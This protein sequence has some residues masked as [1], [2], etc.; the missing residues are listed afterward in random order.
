MKLNTFFKLFIIFILIGTCSKPQE[1]KFKV[2][3][4]AKV[5]SDSTFMTIEKTLNKVEDIRKVGNNAP[6]TIYLPEGTYRLNSTLKISPKYGALKLEGAGIDKTII[7]GSKVLPLQWKKYNDAIW[8]AQVPKDKTFDQIYINGVPQILARYPNYNENGGHWQGHAADA[9]SPERV[10]SWKNPKGG[11]VNV[12]HSGEWGGFHYLV[13]GVDDSGALILSKGHQNNR[14]SKMHD[15]YRMVE[16]IFEELDSPKEWYLS[17]NNQLFYWPEADIDLE[18]ATVEVVQLKHLIDI[19]GTE[20]NPVKN[21]SI[22][23][24]KFEH[25]QR[26]LFED[27]E[28]LLRSDWTIYRGG[29]LFI[30]GTESIKIKDCELTNLG[31][32][33]IFVSS[34]N[35]DVSITNNHIYNCG[36]TAINFV[37]S[38]TA[39]RSPA[40]QYYKFVKLADMDTIKGPKNNKYPSASK[41]DNNLIYRIGRIEKQTAGVNISMAMD[42]TVS[43]NTIYDVPRAG[44]NICDGTWG[45]HIIEQNDVFNTVL[46]T[47]DHGAFNSWGRDRFWHPNRSVLD[48]IVANHPDI[49]KWDAIHT[50]IIRNNRF[51]CD[52]GW[53]IDLDDGSSNY[54]IYNNVCLNGGIKF[55]EGFYRTA[56]NNILINNGFH[57]HVWFKNSED[58]FRKN[59]VLT[60]HK[61]IRLQAWGKEVDFNLFPDETALLKAQK[62]GVDANSRFGNP[63]FKNPKEADYTILEDSPALK[64]GFKNFNMSGFG[65][66]NKTLKALAKQPDIPTIWSASASKKDLIVNW[67]GATLKNIETMAERSAAG[68]NETS[69]VLILGIDD[70]SIVAKSTLEKG[71]VIISAENEKTKIIADLMNIYQNNNWKGVLNLEIYRNQKVQKLKINLK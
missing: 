34:Y 30:E 12:M 29:A 33:A 63:N 16:N 22:S 70:D 51:R 47:S 9:I 43:N 15:T 41:V 27:Y 18:H 58:V 50:T 31:G 8:I 68:L 54:K 7:K 13:E 40:F 28:P 39:V 38:P 24:I 59:I 35:R 48:S 6:I 23:N 62:N 53:D 19:I 20:E 60:A 49:P 67:L 64:L 37:G 71:D 66:K 52:H 69:G 5:D 14:P 61:D 46:E 57:P 36:A 3:S 32:N 11:I 55:R 2:I 10:N 1:L 4:D 56:E 26:T 42:I 21:V 45:G 44:I 17:A 25:T 65:V